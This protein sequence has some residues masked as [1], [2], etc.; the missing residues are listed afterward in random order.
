MNVP[1]PTVTGPLQEAAVSK[2]RHS[3]TTSHVTTGHQVVASIVAH[4][5][6]PRHLHLVQG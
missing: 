3:G 2:G 6:V 1:L 5:D 4:Q